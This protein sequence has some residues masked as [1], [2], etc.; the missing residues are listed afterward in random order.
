M[1]DDVFT[2][3]F[4]GPYRLVA[5]LGKGGMAAVY[6]AVEEFEGGGESPCAVKVPLPAVLAD[7]EMVKQFM[8]EGDIALMVKHRNVLR[9]FGRGSDK[10]VPYLV[11]D[12]VAGKNLAQVQRQMVRRGRTWS[13]DAVA[14]VA[15]EVGEALKYIHEF[16]PGGV[17]MSLVHRDLSS[18]NVLVSGDGGVFICDF[19]VA[20]ASIHQS[21]MSMF[22]GTWQYAAP[23]QVCGELGPWCDVFGLGTML[24]EMIEMR[25]F[26]ANLDE[27]AARNA[28]AAG[29]VPPLTRREVPDVLRWVVEGLLARDWPQRMLI[30]E[31]LRLMDGQTDKR[32]EIRTNVRELF[33]ADVV[34]TG[35]S[36]RYFV[37]PVGLAQTKAIGAL[38]DEAGTRP[39]EHEPDAPAGARRA[40][41]ATDGVQLRRRARPAAASSDPPTSRAP[42]VGEAPAAVA[43]AS[44]CVPTGRE[45]DAGA[46]LRVPTAILPFPEV[47]SVGA[48]TEI[49]TPPFPMGSGVGSRVPEPPSMC[50]FGHGDPGEDAPRPVS[51]R[52]RLLEPN[53]REVVEAGPSTVTESVVERHSTLS[54]SGETSASERRRSGRR[55][56]TALLG[57]AA[58][59][60]GLGTFAGWML[61]R[62]AAPVVPA[63]GDREPAS[64]S[65]PALVSTPE[66]RPEFVINTVVEAP[67][68]VDTPAAAPP[69]LG[70]TSDEP[71]PTA[72]TPTAPTTSAA[73]P[74]AKTRAQPK[75]TLRFRLLTKQAQVRIGNRVIKMSSDGTDSIDLRVAPGRQPLGWKLTDADPWKTSREVFTPREQATVFVGRDGLH[76]ARAEGH[77]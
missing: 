60:M 15:R 26:R 4:I 51:T 12:F 3:T 55:R 70:P 47:A 28:A 62:S 18:K 56:V 71:T 73:R 43:P 5:L 2:P 42:D 41:E 31:M 22:K 7:R 8:R 54:W 64:T 21:E 77:P 76:I 50:G 27:R 16:A 36:R 9:A 48:P 17:P 6:Q 45:S 1:D 20:S 23:E 13:F 67:K 52:L 37:A 74:R 19:G 10:G 57:L 25:P 69:L 32:G 75:A 24:W 72:P 35:L 59:A 38:E 44:V 39:D 49:V 63:A 53:E 33:G 11:L 30:A 58:L 65:T 40:G 61:V 14:H 68:Q 34:R 46:T 66:P 29:D